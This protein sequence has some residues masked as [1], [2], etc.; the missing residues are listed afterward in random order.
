M[1]RTLNIAQEVHN[2][3]ARKNQI[4]VRQGLP[5]IGAKSINKHGI[6]WEVEGHLFAPD[7]A[8]RARDGGPVTTEDA[9][10]LL[11]AVVPLN[12]SPRLNDFYQ[13]TDRCTSKHLM[14]LDTM[15]ALRPRQAKAD[16][17]YV[18]LGS[19][20]ARILFFLDIANLH[21]TI[22]AHEIAHAWIDLVEETNDYRTMR[23]LSDVGKVYQFQFV[24]SFVIDQKVNDVIRERG[25]DMSIM[26][27]QE[28]QALIN[29]AQAIAKGYQPSQIREIAFMALIIATRL[30]K[31]E[32]GV[33]APIEP[34]EAV[35]NEAMDVLKRSLPDAYVLAQQFAA[36]VCNCDYSNRKPVRATLDECLRLSY[37]FTDDSFDLEGDFEKKIIVQPNEDKYPHRFPGLSVPAKLEIGRALAKHNL[38]SSFH[39]RMSRNSSG[40]LQIEFADATKNW[41]QPTV[42]QHA[43]SV[44]ESCCPNFHDDLPISPIKAC[45]Q[46]LP[47]FQSGRPPS[48]FV[49]PSVVSKKQKPFFSSLSEFTNPSSAILPTHLGAYNY[50]PGVAASWSRSRLAQQK[51]NVNLNTNLYDYAFNDP[52]HNLDPSGKYPYPVPAN[53]KPIPPKATCP[54]G[55]V[56]LEGQYRR[57]RLICELDQAAF[58]ANSD[59][60]SKVPLPTELQGN[61]AFK[62]GPQAYIKENCSGGTV[63]NKTFEALPS[64]YQNALWYHEKRRR[65]CCAMYKDARLNPRKDHWKTLQ[66]VY[67]ALR[68][69]NKVPQNVLQACKPQ[70]T[71][72]AG[73]DCAREVK[74]KS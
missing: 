27:E 8:S 41:T 11:P 20:P 40:Q 44:P 56:D 2:R 43:H 72:P 74:R 67:N 7:L 16:V 70:G 26:E 46:N 58:R 69:C 61:P 15:P 37:G 3:L 19:D 52:L 34:Y 49:Q 24:N 60:V 4:A 9:R 33:V 36:A 63:Y 73:G 13:E 45:R 10:D 1:N 39:W 5:A 38:G 29:Y 47:A 6:E 64:I 68:K 51:A 48:R 62:G 50:L 31:L 57:I 25:F 53:P 18:N 14:L 65:H 22:L 28:R 54:L 17:H 59:D 12:L 71:L 30:V 42:L 66:T 35:T 21:E 23:D 55:P 32:K